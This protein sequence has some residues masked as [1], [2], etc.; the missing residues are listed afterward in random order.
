MCPQHSGELESGCLVWG[1]RKVLQTTWA[2]I[3]L[4]SFGLSRK[5]IGQWSYRTDFLPRVPNSPDHTPTKPVA[6]G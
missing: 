2:A 3:I 1:F 6:L 4:P 5:Q